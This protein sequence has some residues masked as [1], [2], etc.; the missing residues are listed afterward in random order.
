MEIGILIYI[1]LFAVL[2]F[3]ILR[4]QRARAAAQKALMAALEPG[5][6]VLT[7]AGLYGQIT[8]LDGDTAFLA[9]ADNLEIK[10]TRE[11]IAER[12]QY[13]DSSVVQDDTDND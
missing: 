11:S 1:A 4:P 6:D 9:I 10:V 12:V 5:D 3:V 2:W 13:A 7:S 8:E